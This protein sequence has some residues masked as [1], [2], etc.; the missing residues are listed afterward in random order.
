MLATYDYQ[1][2]SLNLNYDYS[3]MNIDSYVDLLNNDLSV[4]EEFLMKKQLKN[5]TTTINIK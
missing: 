5:Q 3:S 1:V 2:N 4:K